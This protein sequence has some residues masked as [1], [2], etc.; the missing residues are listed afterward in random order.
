MKYVESFNLH[1]NPFIHVIRKTTHR[2]ADYRETFHAHQG[3]ELQYIHLG[4]GQLIINHQ[5]YPIESHML[6][7]FQPFQLHRLR[8]NITPDTPYTRSF[9]LF[10]P[11]V[12]VK[13]LEGLP[14]MNNFLG[15]LCNDQI[16]SPVIYQLPEDHD[17]VRTLTG[18]SDHDEIEHQA[19]DLIV[20]LRQLFREFAKTTKYKVQKPRPLHR[21]E[22]MMQW[23]ERHYTEPLRLE[24]LATELH[25]SPYHISH[26]FKETTGTSLSEYI[27]ARRLRQACMLLTLSEL[28]VATIGEKIGIES[29]S[30][31]CK[32]FKD[33]MGITPH[34]YRLQW[35]KK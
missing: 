17:L 7:L 8:M 34:Q 15:S 22:Q 19:H 14:W 4:T 13:F 27:K 30:Y 9:V 11:D 1:K 12:Y 33:K 24:V 28:S 16:H 25:M 10:E 35:K 20:I 26:Q 6:C 32:I 29:T 3:M 31:F 5:T 21:V 2:Q 23:I 18:L